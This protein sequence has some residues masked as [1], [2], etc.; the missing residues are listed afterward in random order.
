MKLKKLRHDSR[1]HITSDDKPSAIRAPLEDGRG[2]K[3]EDFVKLIYR[4][5]L[6]FCV[7]SAGMRMDG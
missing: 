7:V 6:N 3:E 5:Y 1:K 4:T 2:A